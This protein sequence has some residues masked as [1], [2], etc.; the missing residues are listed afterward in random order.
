M[1]PEIR[2]PVPGPN[3]QKIVERDTRSIFTTTKT[4]PVAAAHAKGVWVTDVDGNVFLDWTSGVGV[5]NCGYSHPRVTK[6][7][8]EQAAKLVHFAGTDFYYDAQVDLA[9]RLAAAVPGDFAK[10]VFFTNSGTESNEAAIKVA[11]YHSGRGR[12]LAFL[13]GFHGRTMGSLA[14]TASKPVH[15]RHFFPT[16]PGV[17]HA[18]YPNPY[19]N[20]WGIDGYERGDEL[21]DKCIDFIETTL[22]QSNLPPEDVAAVWVE[23]VQ[24]EGGYVVPP[25]AWFPKLRKL[26]DKHGIL[27]VADEV[28]TGFGRA[29]KLFAMEHFGVAADMTCLAKG[30][31]NGMPMGALVARADLDFDVS[32]AHSNTFGGNVLAT[33][34]GLATLD[35]LQQEKLV[36]NAEKVGAY[37]KKRLLELQERHQAIGDVRG[38]GLMLATEFVTDRRTKAYDPKVKDRVV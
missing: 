5:V 19:R 17:A 15:Q 7:I 28:Q 26:C 22:F 33:T 2:V 3:A 31:A 11:R 13:G 27:L 34:A 35:V 25:K 18:M 14:M 6:A 4:S 20:V 8:Q 12:F 9:E 23:P 21:V 29:G 24:G 36:E 16:M 32:G 38:L 10:K 1:K 37:L 30:I